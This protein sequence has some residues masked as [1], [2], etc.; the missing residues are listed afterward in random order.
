MLYMIIERYRDPAEVYRR[1]RDEGR[2]LPT[3]LEYRHSWVTPELERC[4][5]VMETED[6]T[7]LEDWLATWANLVEFEVVP[8]ISADEAAAAIADEL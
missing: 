8:V 6:R 4:Y 5:Q 1:L 3:G 2:G 7:I